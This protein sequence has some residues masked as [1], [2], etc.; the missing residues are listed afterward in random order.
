MSRPGSAAS[1]PSRARPATRT[2]SNWA[3]ASGVPAFRKRR[4]RPARGC[5]SPTGSGIPNQYPRL[6]GQHAEYT[7]A[8]LKA[9]RDG[10]R[11]NNV[12]MQQIAARLTDA[13]M[14]AVA[15]YIQGLRK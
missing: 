9:F 15:D 2:R 7:E 13:E 1:P 12:P 11:R 8:T 3:S 6:A 14:R 10:T 5:H 4:C